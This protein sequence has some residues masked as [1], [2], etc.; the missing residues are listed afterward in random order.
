MKDSWKDEGKRIRI[1][2]GGF[3][4]FGFGFG[5][6]NNGDKYP[7]DRLT[8]FVKHA[9]PLLIYIGSNIVH[10]KERGSICLMIPS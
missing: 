10:E 5:V 9:N 8:P 2:L 3:R 1:T 4:R 7:D 6:S